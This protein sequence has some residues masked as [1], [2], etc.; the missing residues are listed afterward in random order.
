M[1]QFSLFEESEDSPLFI[2]RD[3]ADIVYIPHWIDAREADLLYKQLAAELNWEQSVISL[4]GKATKIPRL[5]AW[6]ADEGCDYK[7]SNHQLVRRDW[8]DP[9]RDLRLRGQRVMA[10]MASPQEFNSVLANLYRDGRDSVAYHAD[11]EPELGPNPIIASI[12]LGAPRRFLMKHRFDTKASRIEIELGHGSLLIMRGETQKNWLHS[13]P[14]ASK[15]TE[16]RINLTFRRI[17]NRF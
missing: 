15:V 4:Y 16:P 8:V 14:K 3:G 1:T 5:N 9:L 11:D 17:V 2:N 13:V 7:Y 10:E 6:Y 12:S